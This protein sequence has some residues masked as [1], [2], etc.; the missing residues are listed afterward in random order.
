MYKGVWYLIDIIFCVCFLCM[1]I[2]EIGIGF[3]DYKGLVGWVTD[4]GFWFAEIF[5]RGV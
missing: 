5:G 2:E 4:R 1:Y 3:I